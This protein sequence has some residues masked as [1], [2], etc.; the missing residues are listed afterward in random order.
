MR[1]VK[2]EN[3]TQCR[4]N[5]MLID[6]FDADDKAGY[7]V[8]CKGRYQVAGH[9][10]H[11]IE[12]PTSLNTLELLPQLQQAGIKAIKIEGRQ[13][14][15]AYVSRVVNIWREAIDSCLQ[16]PKTFVVRPQWM[17]GLASISEGTQTTLGAYNR[18]WQ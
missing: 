7:P 16:D 4:L 15:T 13:R 17:Q 1:W 6:Q 18:P 5:E 10:Y 11:A 3:G 2:T 8:V 14:S 12:E 9:T